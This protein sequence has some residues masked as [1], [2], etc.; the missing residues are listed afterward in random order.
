[1]RNILLGKLFS[2]GANKLIIC[3]YKI[4]SR[5]IRIHGTLQEIPNQFIV[6]K[7]DPGFVLIRHDF[8]IYNLTK[9]EKSL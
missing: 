3:N 2:I 6:V 7:I 9:Y 4:Y 5:N 8:S 1:M